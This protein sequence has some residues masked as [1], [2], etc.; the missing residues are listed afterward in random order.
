MWDTYNGSQKFSQSKNIILGINQAVSSLKLKAGLHII[1]DTE[2]AVA[3]TTGMN[4]FIEKVFFEKLAPPP[5]FFLINVQFDFN[6]DT[7]R[8]DA[9]NNL[10]KIGSF[11]ATHPQI[12][13]T[14]EGHTCDMGSER[15]N[16]SLSRQRAESVKKYMILKFNI[17]PVRLTTVEYGFSRPIAANAT[18]E[19]RQ[20]NRRVMATITNKYKGRKNCKSSA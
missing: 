9:T 2:N 16:R 15:Y 20:Q 5:V 8:P 10:D 3:S 18:E 11:L 13:I 4:G 1:G 6:K 7:I 14:L 19:G 17:T 12:V